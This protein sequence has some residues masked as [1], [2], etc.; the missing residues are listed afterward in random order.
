MLGCFKLILRA[1]G[2]LDGED[3]FDEALE[4]S[5]LNALVYHRAGAK[6][7]I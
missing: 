7:R 1:V 5:L 3:A 6:C 4:G 2:L